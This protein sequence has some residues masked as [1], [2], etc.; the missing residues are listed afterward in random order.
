MLFKMPFTVFHS[1]RAVTAN[2]QNCPEKYVVNIGLSGNLLLLPSGGPF[3]SHLEHGRKYHNAVAK[4][5]EWSAQEEERKDPEFCGIIWLGRTTMFSFHM[6]P[7]QEFK[8]LLG[9]LANGRSDEEIREMQI[10]M[11]RLG[12]IIFDSWLRHRNTLKDLRDK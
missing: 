6:L 9:T 8:R 2:A 7:M 4:C 10:R 11:D 3:R 1:L 12:N 5:L